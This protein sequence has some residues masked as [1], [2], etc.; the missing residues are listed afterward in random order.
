MGTQKNCLNETVLLTSEHPKHMIKLMGGKK[1][2]ILHWKVWFIIMDL[3]CFQ[4]K[5]ECGLSRT[6]VQFIYILRKFRCYTGLDKLHDKQYSQVVSV[7][8]L[9]ILFK[10]IV[11][12]WPA[13][14][15]IKV[16]FKA[17][18]WSLS[19]CTLQ[20]MTFQERELHFP[21]LFKPVWALALRL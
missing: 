20:V 4:N 2:T 18:E 19:T 14:I 1:F 10:L 9:K 11:V 8:L 16:L 12:M 6:R 13:F 5:D 3:Q 21:V 15:K 17:S 7:T